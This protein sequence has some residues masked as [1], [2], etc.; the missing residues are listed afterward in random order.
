MSRLLRLVLSQ[1]ESRT[2]VRW[3]VEIDEDHKVASRI[4]RSTP[5]F[6][7]RRPPVSWAR[8]DDERVPRD[9]RW[10]RP[11]LVAAENDVELGVYA[12]CAQ[13]FEELVGFEWGYSGW[14][15]HRQRIRNRAYMNELERHGNS[16]REIV[17]NACSRERGLDRREQHIN[18]VGSN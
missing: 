3:V 13:A 11:P 2:F 14:R 16:G 17:A 1:R 12:G 7:T 5:A 8:E 4:E 9:G 10:N 18:R 15:I 6:G